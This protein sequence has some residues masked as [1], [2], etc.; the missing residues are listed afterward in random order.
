VVGGVVLAI[1]VVGGWAGWYLLVARSSALPLAPAA[2]T[3]D[4]KGVFGDAFGVLGSL[5]TA[6]G[7]VGAAAALWFQALAHREEARREAER[8]EIELFLT[9]LQRL[10]SSRESRRQLRR[11]SN[12]EEFGKALAAEYGKDDPSEAFKTVDAVAREFDI[13]GLL[14]RRRIASARLIRRFYA[15]AVVDLWDTTVLQHYVTEIRKNPDSDHPYRRGPVH[16]WE[17]SQS[18]EPMRAVYNEHPVRTGRADWPDG[19]AV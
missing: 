13:L 5:F 9:A 8:L 4:H 19:D 3:P 11:M 14:F 17:L 1:L 2:D 7:F 18:I 6:L 12:T 16:Y 10:E 15:T